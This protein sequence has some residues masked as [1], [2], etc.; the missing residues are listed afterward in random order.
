MKIS[1][2]FQYLLPHKLLS[3]LIGYLA[4]SRFYLIK[5]SFIRLFAKK[6]NI[7][8][9]EYEIQSFGDFANFEEFFTRKI[10]LEN[11]PMDESELKLVSPAD[12]VVSDMRQHFEAPIYVKGHKYELQQLLGGEEALE[13]TNGSCMN[14]YLSPKDYHRVHAPLGG[15]L[16]ALRYIPGRLYSVNAATSEQ[17]TGLFAKNERLVY[18]FDSPQGP[19]CLV[20]VGAMIVSGI[21]TPWHGKIVSQIKNSNLDLALAP[22]KVQ[23]GEEIGSFFLGSSVVMLFP[24]GKV[25][26]SEAVQ[27][28]DFVQLRSNLG[29]LEGRE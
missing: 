8:L 18:F 26:W 7:S 27:L 3:K 5:N 12:G 24:V 15:S 16:K 20:M 28:G 4:Q 14:I 29:R 11:R 17:V 22:I 6:Y 2:I 23:K 19:F 21:S 13:F 25:S 1:I 10:K 9:E